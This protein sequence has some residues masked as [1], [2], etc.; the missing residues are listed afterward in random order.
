[1]PQV[2]LNKAEL[3]IILSDLAC[4][5][6]ELEREAEMLRQLENK[7]IAAA[8][9]SANTSC[10]SDPLIAQSHRCTPEPCPRRLPVDLWVEVLEARRDPPF[11]GS[12]G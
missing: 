9:V 1:M 3:G 5:R 4:R 6:L 7:L 12:V 8:Q 10:R 11:I 2:E